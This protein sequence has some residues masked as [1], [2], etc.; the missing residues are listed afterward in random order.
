MI[1]LRTCGDY[2]VPPPLCTRA[3][4]AAGTRSS[5]RLLLKVAAILKIPGACV[6]GADNLCLFRSRY[7]ARQADH[8]I[9]MAGIAV[10]RDRAISGQFGLTPR[11]LRVPKRLESRPEVTILSQGGFRLCGGAE[12]R[13]P[14]LNRR[15]HWRC[16]KTAAMTPESYCEPFGRSYLCPESKSKTPNCRLGRLRVAPPAFDD[17]EFNDHEFHRS[18]SSDPSVP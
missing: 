11:R 3:A 14:C 15:K 5:L 1:P 18:A 16:G 9:A 2:R 7:R 6:A 12:A 4:G 17:P 8:E 13:I 10:T